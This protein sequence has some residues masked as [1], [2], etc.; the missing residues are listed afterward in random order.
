MESDLAAFLSFSP[1]AG[2]APGSATTGSITLPSLSLTGLGRRKAS[3]PTTPAM[4]R[5]ENFG[6]PGMQAS[7]HFARRTHADQ[8][9]SAHRGSSNPATPAAGNRELYDG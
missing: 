3:K 6:S 2:R 5:K 8:C 9:G 7:A 4:A 1:A